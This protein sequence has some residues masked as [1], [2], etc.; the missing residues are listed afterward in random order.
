MKIASLGLL[1]VAVFVPQFGFSADPELAG[2]WK[3]DDKAGNTALDSS[4]AKHAGKFFGE[5]GRTTGKFGGALAFNGKDSYVDIPNS[6]DL[7]QIQNGSYAIAAW[8]KP[9]MVP[10]GTTETANDAEFGIVLKGGWHE[11]LSYSRNKQFTMH[12]WLAGDADPVWNGIGTWED[13]YQPGEWYH[14]V[15]VVDQK[16]RVVKIFVNGELRNT[17]EPWTS[18]AKSRDYEQQT[19]KIGVAAPGSDQYAWYAKGAV[20]DVRIYK[21]ALTEE[22]VKSLYKAG[23][24]GTAK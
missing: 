6:K 11:G 13:E 17:T 3:L 9:E 12:H 22:Q 1:A 7:D 24:N 23:A 2:H 20:G 4:A 18:G 14:L 10:P 19:W 5:P 16:D 8:F 15:G 21:G